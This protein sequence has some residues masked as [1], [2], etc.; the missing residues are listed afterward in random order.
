VAVVMVDEVVVL[1]GVVVLDDVVVLAEAADETCG[2][3][4][5]AWT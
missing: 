4:W 3:G 5:A 2:S 1:D